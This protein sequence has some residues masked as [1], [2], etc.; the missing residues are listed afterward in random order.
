M[1]VPSSIEFLLTLENRS[2]CHSLIHWYHLQEYTANVYFRLSAAQIT[3]L[4]DNSVLVKC[5]IPEKFQFLCNNNKLDKHI[6]IIWLVL[7]NYSNIL[8]LIFSKN[9]FVM[10]WIVVR[11]CHHLKTM[12]LSVSTVIRERPWMKE[13]MFGFENSNDDMTWKYMWYNEINII[14]TSTKILVHLLKN[15]HTTWIIF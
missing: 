6:Q 11:Y 8:I 1:F 5:E 2:L 12:K 4:S 3:W 10:T 9:I 13:A 14:N 15:E 7:L